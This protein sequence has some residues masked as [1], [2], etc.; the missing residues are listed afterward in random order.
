VEVSEKSMNIFCKTEEL[1]N[2]VFQE[3]YIQGIVIVFS[4]I[5]LLYAS[6]V[7]SIWQKK[8]AGHRLRRSHP[9]C[10]SNNLPPGVSRY[11][12]KS[13]ANIF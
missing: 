3:R 13:L 8:Y 9:A 6:S 12:V 7:V 11:D 5:Y 2:N 10:P 1:R 4:S